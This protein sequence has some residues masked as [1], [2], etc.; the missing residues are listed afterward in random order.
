MQVIHLKGR[1]FD[2]VGRV[3]HR[4][5]YNVITSYLTD[6]AISMRHAQE[7]DSWNRECW[8]L[9]KPLPCYQTGE[10]KF[11][12]LWRTMVCNREAKGIA[13]PDELGFS[14][15]WWV[16][17]FQ[18]SVYMLEE[19]LSLM[20][21]TCPEDDD[22]TKFK[23]TF[24]MVC[25][26]LAYQLG[27]RFESAFYE[28]APRRKFFMSKNEFIGWVPAAAQEDDMLCLFEHCW[29]PFVIRPI[30]DGYQLIGE[31]YVHGVMD[32]QPKQVQRVPFESIKLI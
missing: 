7:M 20:E 22:W 26:G 31:A 14:Y 5:P 15:T 32:E 12:A 13:A 3:I 24:C 1:I 11:D 18:A 16:I 10:S 8:D 19:T 4:Q 23:I 6:T 25:L 27:Q 2:T 30:A 9:V 17:G 28:Y 29:L 21:R